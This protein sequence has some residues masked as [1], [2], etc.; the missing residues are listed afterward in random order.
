MTESI[1]IV[2]ADEQAELHAGQRRIVASIVR[3]S[4]IREM[5][6]LRLRHPSSHGKPLV[7]WCGLGMPWDTFRCLLRQVTINSRSNSLN[8]DS[9]T[10]PRRAHSVR[11]MDDRR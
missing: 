7:D 11:S 8:D 9:V 10:N 2:P 1:R 6:L 4:F 5:D 3:N